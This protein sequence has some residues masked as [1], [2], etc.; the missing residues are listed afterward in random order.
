MLIA[1][2]HTPRRLQPREL[3]PNATHREFI[4]LANPVVYLSI[5]TVCQKI[6]INTHAQKQ[7]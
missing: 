1:N 3:K 4:S 5:A 2:T 6:N 7:K